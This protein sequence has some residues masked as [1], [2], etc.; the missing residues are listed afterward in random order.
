MAMQTTQTGAA[1][2]LAGMA[3]I[4]LIDNFILEVAKYSGL[5]QFHLVR[6]LMALPM[7]VVLA[8]VTG[9]D[10]LPQRYWAVILRAVLLATSM[11]LYFGSIPAMPI[12]LVIAG[13]FTSPV[14]VLIFSALFF[15]VRVGHMRIMAVVIGFIGV[16]CVLKPFG[17][18]F[19]PSLILPVIA[20]ALYAL[21]AIVSRRYCAD[22]STIAMLVVFFVV[23]TIYG[24]LGLFALNGT[25]HTT[26]LTRDWEGLSAPFLSWTLLQAAGSILG[27]RLLTRAYQSTETTYLVVFEYSLILF[28]SFWAFVL[29]GQTVGLLA[30]VGMA[31]IVTSGVIIALR[32]PS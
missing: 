24:A 31:L 9:Q 16:L 21:N 29:Y 11:L 13:L 3:V 22:E 23:L 6:G 26:F 5:W 27:V 15:G 7:L 30:F 14:F 2:V 12:A 10:L 18:S 25:D 1:L 4:G 32:S 17:E 19:S 8:R 20:G 28:A